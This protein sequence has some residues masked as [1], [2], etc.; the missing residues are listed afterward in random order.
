MIP[1]PPVPDHVREWVQDQVAG[2]RDSGIPSTSPCGNYYDWH[3]TQPCPYGLDIQNYYHHFTEFKCCEH[4][5][6]KLECKP[7]NQFLIDRGIYKGEM[8]KD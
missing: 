8:S 1:P 5:K 6:C 2:L 4:Q 7:I 3:Q